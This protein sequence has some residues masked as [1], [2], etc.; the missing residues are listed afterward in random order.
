[1]HIYNATFFHT[2]ALKYVME[3]SSSFSSLEFP[4]KYEAMKLHKCISL[5]SYYSSHKYFTDLICELYIENGSERKKKRK[6]VYFIAQESGEKR[7]NGIDGTVLKASKAQV[8]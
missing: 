4:R 8:L 6:N 3:I 1:M 5:S 2:I 7:A